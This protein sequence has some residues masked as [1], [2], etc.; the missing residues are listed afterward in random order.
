MLNTFLNIYDLKNYSDF[1]IN[2]N[3]KKIN[4]FFAGLENKIISFKDV[5]KNEIK[6]TIF[7]ISCNM[8]AEKKIIKRLK[9]LDKSVL[10][11]SIFPL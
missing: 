5:K 11:F 9:F 7:F 2:D 4:K 8:S 1:V 6:K 10:F 3:K